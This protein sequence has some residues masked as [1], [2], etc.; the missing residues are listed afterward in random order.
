MGENRIRAKL[1]AMAMHLASL[2]NMLFSTPFAM[3]LAMPLAILLAMPSA[4]RLTS[5]FT[6]K[7]FDK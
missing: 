4:M 1:L 3:L 6:K 7:F 5:K 2:L